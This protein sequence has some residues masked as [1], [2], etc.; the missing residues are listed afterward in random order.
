MTTTLAI[1][2]RNSADLHDLFAVERL[3]AIVALDDEELKL[4]DLLQRGKAASAGFTL[5]TPFNGRALVQS[6]RLQN[7]ISILAAT[8]RTLHD[9]K[10]TSSHPTELQRA[11][12]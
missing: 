7:M 10:D 6:T 2:C 9:V 1:T 11:A 3:A 4:L 8:E 12:V 5:P